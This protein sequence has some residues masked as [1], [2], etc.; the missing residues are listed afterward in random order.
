MITT[1][2][3]MGATILAGV[4]L[5]ACSGESSAPAS[6]T[7]PAVPVTVSM[8]TTSGGTAIRVSG[9]LE[10]SANAVMSTRVMGF[11]TSIRV[12]PGDRVSKG[13]LLLTIN[14]ADILA[15]RSQAQAM[16]NEAEAALADAKR[17]YDRYQELYKQKSASL[18]EVENMSLRYAS[19]QAKAEVARQ[20][21]READAML[22]YTNLTAPFAGVV[23]QKFAE[24]GAMATPGMPLLAVEEAGTYQVITSVSASEVKQVHAGLAATITIPAIEKTITGTVSEVSPSATLSGGRY[25]VKV[26]L[27]SGE[28]EGLYSGMSVTVAMQTASASDSEIMVPVSALVKKDQLTA[29]YT[30]SQQGTALL[31]W[32]KTGRTQG[33]QVVVLAGLQAAEPFITKAEGKLYNGVPVLILK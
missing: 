23:T 8:P 29:L 11:I 20:M 18:K 21:M 7:V 3:R 25:P 17:D 16:M 14:S 13:Q 28:R 2:G 5:A 24:E 4:L 12:K 26:R 6:V 19:V 15:K 10:S 9:Q 1:T 30:V 31:R 22:A 32:V 27:S 33:D